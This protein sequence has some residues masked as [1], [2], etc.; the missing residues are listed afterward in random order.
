MNLST[1]MFLIAFST[2]LIIIGSITWLS[3]EIVLNDYEAMEKKDIQ[4]E[5]LRTKEA[6]KRIEESLALITIDWAHW[7]D[8][9][10]FLAGKNTSFKKIN[11]MNKVSFLDTHSDFILFFD[12]KGRYFEGNAL[13]KKQK[14]FVP[15]S[16]NLIDYI[17]KNRIILQ[18]QSPQD[19]VTGFIRIPEGLLLLTSYAVSDSGTTQKPNGN[20]ILAYFFEKKDLERLAKTLQVQL[21]LYYLEDIAE[22]TELQEIFNKLKTVD[23]YYIVPHDDKIL[24]YYSLLNDIN[25]KPIA[26]LRTT[27]PRKTF[28]EGL[29]TIHLY[30]FIVALIG[31]IIMGLVFFLLK[32]SI[33][34]RINSFKDQL[35]IITSKQDFSKTIEMS[36]RDEIYEMG[37]DCNKMLQVINTTQAQ[38]NQSIH[39]LTRSNNLIK[40]N[41]EELKE[42]EH[43][44][45]LI[46]KINEKLQMC[47]NISEAYSL[48]NETVDELFTGWR[49][50][51]VI[52]DPTSGELKTVTEWGDKK[53]LKLSFHSD[54][55]WAIR[56]GTI[57]IVDKFRTHLDCRHYI[58]NEIS[59]SLCIPLIAVGKFIGILNLN[60]EKN[61]AVSN[62][63][64]QQ[65]VITLSEVI[66]LS[67]ANINLRDSLRDQSIHDP[68]TGLFNR[69]YLEERFPTEIERAIRNK[70]IFSVGMIDIDF[71]KNFNDRYGHAAGDEVLKKLAVSLMENFRGYDVIFRFGGEEFLVI[72]IDN[73]VSKASERM[74]FFREQV[75]KTSITF[76]H[77]N[78]PPITISIGLVEAPTEGTSL[79]EIARKAD[80]ALYHAKENGRDRVEIFTE[81]KSKPIGPN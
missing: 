43:A 26:I 4:Q 74:N 20:V 47:Q 37:K 15:V 19:T 54:E 36:G 31:L 41:N 38:L 35:S 27:F 18:H 49:G 8:A 16:K 66:A 44:M 79:E 48:I 63:Y 14:Q 11:L 57:Y 17:Y 22:N 53:T 75:K 33:L 30:I 59:K 2:I 9:Y 12:N 13:D 52:A 61:T 7:D 23:D 1:K 6:L 25:S 34:R 60:S 42:R 5:V 58:S 69:R 73:S 72:L 65:L 78:L 71:F 81:N 56:S 67:F 76:K 50:G 29:S 45:M 21:R 68:L 28:L 64:H 32:F 77:I 55:C 10:E 46:N 24:Y 62:Y 51:I 40:R 80:I 39:E 3:Y 70:S